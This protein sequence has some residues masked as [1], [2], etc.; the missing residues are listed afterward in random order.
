MVDQPNDDVPRRTYDDEDYDQLGTLL[1][2]DE[3]Q[4]SDNSPINDFDPQ[5]L[6]L[7]Q[8]PYLNSSLRNDLDK[9][10][11]LS[12]QSPG[13]LFNNKDVVSH[14]LDVQATASVM[15]NNDIVV[16][17]LFSGQN[18]GV[19]HYRNEPV[20]KETVS[21]T[22]SGVDENNTE[23]VADISSEPSLDALEALLLREI[24]NL[25]E[26]FKQFQGQANLRNIDEL[27]K[28]RIMTIIKHLP[29]DLRLRYESEHRRRV[30]PKNPM[31]IDISNVQY[32][33]SSSDE[34]FFIRLLLASSIENPAGEICLH[35]NKLGYVSNNEEDAEVLDDGTLAVRLTADDINNGIKTFTDL[36]MT[37][38][39]LETYNRQLTP[40]K[41][42]GI[43]DDIL[44]NAT[45]KDVAEAKTIFSTYQLEVNW[46]ICQLVIK[47]NQSLT[48][49]DIHCL[50][51]LEQPTKRSIE[52]IEDDEEEEEEIE[53]SPSRSKSKPIKRKTIFH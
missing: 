49:T 4:C 2:F 51:Y 29:A 11:P 44:G 35:P 14:S 21:T 12:F 50:I 36:S 41:L 47:Q 10:S 1:S 26:E 43:A 38:R 39:T 18:L 22:P 23:T 13:D 33:Q 24:K 20:N 34:T 9:Y 42:Y 52:P 37:K 3:F 25:M 31:K 30:S 53:K 5:M 48:Y 16:E 46:I 45:V 32:I 19:I 8:V 40:L 6:C 15:P 7:D 17:E 28:E 27:I